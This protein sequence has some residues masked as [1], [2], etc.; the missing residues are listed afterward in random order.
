MSYADD[1]CYNQKIEPWNRR[2]EKYRKFIS[3]TKYESTTNNESII[4]NLKENSGEFSYHQ[5]TRSA[6]KN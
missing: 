3:K 2:T 5:T 1:T 4:T 6:T